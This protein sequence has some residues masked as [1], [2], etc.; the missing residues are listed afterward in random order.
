MVL[1]AASAKPFT[2]AAV[3]FGGIDRAFASVRR[4]TKAGHGFAQGLVDDLAHVGRVFGAYSGNRTR[5]GWVSWKKPV[6]I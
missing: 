3:I 5:S 4:S 2:W 1:P 6:P